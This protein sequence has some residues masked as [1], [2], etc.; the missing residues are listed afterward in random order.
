MTPPH[1]LATADSV[2]KSAGKATRRTSG[3]SIESLLEKR[4]ARLLIPS[5]ADLFFLALLVWLFASSGSGGEGLLGDADAG[6]H[7]RTGEYIL[8]HHAVPYQDLYSFSKAG[9]P[10]FA[11]E[12]LADV[13]DALV[14]RAAGLKGVIL[15]AAVMITAFGTLLIRRM[16]YRGTHLF[17]ALAVALL[18][19]GAASIHFLARPHVFTL[20]LLAISMW[21]I[22]ADRL[23]PTRRVWWLVPI[24]MVWTNLHGGF[25]S[26]IAVLGLTAIGTAAEVW[27]GNG[28]TIRDA[29]RYLKLTIA[30]GLATLVN[31]YGWNLHKHVI[32][33]L[34]SDWIKNVV[35]E[36]Q[37]PAFRNE[38]MMQFEGLLL[39]GLIVAGTLFRRRQISEGLWIVFWAHMSLASVRH[40]PIFVTVTTPVLAAQLSD[41]WKQWSAA[42]KKNSLTGILNQMAAD[43]LS[44]FR[45]M[46][47]LP[48]AVVAGLI[49]VGPAMK[50]PKDFP[51]AIFPTRL[52]HEHA[53]LIA[54]SRV[55]TTDQWGDYLIY[56]NPALKVFV[57]GRSDFYGPEIG[58]QYLQISGG[59]WRW[60]P[61]MEQYQF[62]LVLM[63]VTSAI[64]QLLKLDPE[65]SIAD[66][67]ADGKRILLVRN[68]VI[69]NPLVLNPLQNQPPVDL[70]LSRKP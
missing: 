53:D 19:M 55:F 12:W 66:S 39:V 18:G 25:L 33:Y 47:I 37:S 59:D 45:R 69:A 51:D 48:W 28:R 50:W 41:W 35:Q 27:L 54:R 20:L 52:V 40:V 15:L 36:F 65:W 34:R 10:W 23:H 17:I 1:T 7:I 60:K 56:T 29:V 68:K 46:S 13:I 21:I 49:L 67:D 58:N 11:W 32:E 3:R 62:D 61:L 2:L 57:D 42:D 9:Q 31:P 64:V 38:N 26:L 44:G 6:W 70:A 22:E 8:D 5:L 43:S 63:P 16:A 14:H 4:W 30:C 24:T